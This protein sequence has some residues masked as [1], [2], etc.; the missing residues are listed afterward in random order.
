MVLF[1]DIDAAQWRENDALRRILAAVTEAAGL[2]RGCIDDTCLRI[3]SKMMLIS[4]WENDIQ[5]NDQL[6]NVCIVDSI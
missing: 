2:K 4:Y 5:S 3:A 6:F 1:I